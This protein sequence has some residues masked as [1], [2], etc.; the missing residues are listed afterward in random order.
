[1]ITLERSPVH[2]DPEILVG[3]IIFKKNWLRLLLQPVLKNV[4]LHPYK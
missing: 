4:Q 2:S 1:M 3:I